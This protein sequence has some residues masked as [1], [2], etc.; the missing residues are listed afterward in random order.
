MVRN[1]KAQA[2]LTDGGMRFECTA[3]DSYKIDIDYSGSGRGTTSLEVFLSS[4][5][6]CLAATFA[7]MIQRDGTKIDELV[8]SADGSRRQRHPRSFEIIDIDVKIK[9]PGADR[10]YI[11][12]ALEAAHVKICPVSAMIS[13]NVQ[14]NYNLMLEN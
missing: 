6:S 12:K 13:G 10:E 4:L 2:E 3:G 1:L 7:A 5:C 14:V 11:E 9:S 8:V